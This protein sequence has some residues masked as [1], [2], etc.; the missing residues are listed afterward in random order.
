MSAL[1]PTAPV[2][3]A[4]LRPGVPSTGEFTTAW[5][6]YGC[7]LLGLLIWWPSLVGVIISYMRRN[8]PAAGFIGSHYRWMIRSFWWSTLGW[9]T[10][11]ALLIGGVVPIARDVLRSASRK[12][13]GGWH[14]D[15]L[16]SIDWS[17]LFASATLA[18]IGGTG[19][20]VT[21][22]WMAYRLIRG[23]LRLG[24]ALPAP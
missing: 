12:P 5:I 17:S 8:E 6:A 9:L 16:V 18:T 21:T 11:W 22:L 14:I 24:N 23:G 20:L 2:A 3:D 1:P 13:D 10:S 15:T 19:L 4:E 7:F